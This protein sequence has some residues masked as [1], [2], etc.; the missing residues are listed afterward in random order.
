[1]VQDVIWRQ[2]L[3][4]CFRNGFFYGESGET[5]SELTFQPSSRIVRCR[6]EE[7]AG[8]ESNSSRTGADK[9]ESLIIVSSLERKL[10]R[11]P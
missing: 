6:P 2:F 5:E 10:R 4:F 3:L 11:E 1:M 8:A 9:E 7:R